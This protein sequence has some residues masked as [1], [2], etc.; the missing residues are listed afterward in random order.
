MAVVDFP[1]ASHQPRL[2]LVDLAS[3]NTQ[4]PLVAHGKVSDPGNTGISRKLIGLDPQNNAAEERAI[5]IHAAR[6]VSAEMAR[7]QGRIGRSQGCFAVAQSDLPKVLT[8]L[9][10]GGCFTP[11]RLDLRCFGSLSGTSHA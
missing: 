8:R 11:T 4:T 2:H 10:P 9:G 5:V 6:Y 7:D 1:A 3:G